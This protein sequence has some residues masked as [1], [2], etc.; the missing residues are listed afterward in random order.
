MELSETVYGC[1]GFD[2]YFAITDVS[3]GDPY[4]RWTIYI[5]DMNGNWNSVH[6]FECTPGDTEYSFTT[7]EVLP[8]FDAYVFVMES[9]ESTECAWSYQL[10]NFIIVS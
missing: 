10:Y 1:R 8:A 6:S 7:D 9:P 5:R 3:Y 4:G 2:F